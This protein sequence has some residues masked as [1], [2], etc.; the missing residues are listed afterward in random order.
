MFE[1]LSQKLNTVF[2]GL[3]GVKTL[4]EDGLSKVLREIRLSLLEADVALPVVRTILNELKEKM[5]GEKAVKETSPAETFTK[6]VHDELVKVLGEKTAPLTL[7]KKPSVILMVGLQGVGKTTSAAKLGNLLKT[8]EGKSIL[9][10]SADIY[11]AAAQDQLQTLCDQIGIDKLTIKEGEKPA[12]IAKRALKEAEKYDVL[13]FD[14]AGRTHI[15]DQM[16]DEA[17]ALSKKLNPVETL[18]VADAMQGQESLNVAKNFHEKLNLTGVILTRLDGDARGGVALSVSKTLGLPIKFIGIGEKIEDLD[19][20][21]PDR[22][23]GRIL[24]MGDVV[25]LVEHAQA[26]MDTA[27]VEDTTHKMLSG[28]FNLNDMLNQMRQVK[29]LGSM[30]KILKFLPGMGG[31][32]EKLQSAGMN[33]KMVAHQ[34]AILLSMTPKERANPALILK[35]RKIRI[36]KGSGRPLGEIEKLLKQHEKMKKMMKQLQG[37]GGIEALAKNMPDNI[38]GI[39]PNTFFKK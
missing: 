30:K 14:T 37:A 39:D 21:H 33:D 26:K 12:E 4:T 13:I 8:K 10:A 28:E 1:K 5:I 11:R 36:A 9:M 7:D 17:V 18:F 24:G 22:M 25:S 35:A 23:A 31:L 34:E 3:R 15:D 2:D 32:T 29:K 19:T 27:S 20:F 16:M 38:D 6:A